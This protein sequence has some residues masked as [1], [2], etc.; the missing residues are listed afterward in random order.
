MY[1][2]A[3]I[4][5]DPPDRH[6]MALAA[7]A[8]DRLTAR[9][10]KNDPPRAKS[11]CVSLLGDALQPHGGAIWLGDLIALLRP[12]GINERLLRTSVFRLVSEGWLHAERHGRRSL[13]R[14]SPQ[15][16]RNTSHAAQRIY[17]GAE[18]AW[19]GDWTVVII[20]RTGNNG[21]AERTELRRAL[22]WEGY[23]MVAPGVFAHPRARP[24]AAAGILESLG[25]PDKALVLAARDLPDASALP[26]AALASQCWDLAGLAEQYREFTRQFAP[27]EKTLGDGGGEADG[28]PRGEAGG[29][30]PSAA[31]S[32][33]M[34]LLHRWRR[35]V[36]HDPQLPADMLP[37]E[38]PGH[39]ARALC[40][41]LYWA[42]FDAS[43]THLADIAGGNGE[44]FL[45]LAPDTLRRFGGRTPTGFT[46]SGN[47]P[48]ST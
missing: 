26:L 2:V 16:A 43:E 35:I 17:D 8:L 45:R 13:Y 46:P 5:K 1:H 20:P 12:L 48:G 42:L 10:L 39:A 47:A 14:L 6:A 23:G 44:H 32:A 37:A 41:R 33:R 21:L 40:R 18:A 28:D 30:P 31:F 11:L 36:L 19:S 22:E 24:D 29:A 27:L 25:I 4:H 7:S 38:W 9:L 15:G 3:I 34:L